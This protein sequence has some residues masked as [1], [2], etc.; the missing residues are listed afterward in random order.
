MQGFNIE[1]RF[2]RGANDSILISIPDDYVSADTGNYPGAATGGNQQGAF[3]RTAP[4]NITDATPLEVEA[5][6]LFR[7][8]KITI[9]D[10]TPVYI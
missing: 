1:L 5:D 3:I 10:S 7:N 8:L 4:H 9:E 2:D 6:I